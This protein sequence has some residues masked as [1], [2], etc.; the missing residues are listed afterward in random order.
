MLQKLKR[1]LAFVLLISLFLVLVSC[2]GSDLYY[3]R[4]QKKSKGREMNSRPCVISAFLFAF[5][6]KCVSQFRGSI[7]RGHGR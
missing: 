1:V 7:C 2:D 4:K 3:I 6:P 5:M